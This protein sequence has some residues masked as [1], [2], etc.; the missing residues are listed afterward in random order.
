MKS[1]AEKMQVKPGDKVLVL[2]PPEG[3]TWR[4]GPAD[5]Q[6][7]PGRLYDHILSFVRQEGEIR[8]GLPAWKA[9][10][11]AGGKLWVAWPKAKKLGSDLKLDAVVKA[12]YPQGLVESVNLA[13][14]ETWTALKFTW[15]KPGKV[16]RDHHAVLI[17]DPN[18]PAE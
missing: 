9:S 14:D 8:A 3:W 4:F 5:D 11:G 6:A 12:V 15:P 10:I 7:E 1:L 17:R 2:N 18:Q 16:Y 13:V